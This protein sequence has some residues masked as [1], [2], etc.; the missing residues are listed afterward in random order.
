M[1]ALLR[2]VLVISFLNLLVS[3]SLFAQKEVTLNIETKPEYQ[4]IIKRYKYNTKAT[5]SLSAIQTI[6][7]LVK[8]LH[9][10]GY[11]LANF[12]EIRMSNGEMNAIV[13][14]GNPFEWL[15][16]SPGNIDKSI[17]RKTAY[18][19]SRF[20]NDRFDYTQ[21]ANIENKVLSYAEENGYPFAAISYDSLRIENNQFSASLNLE[22]G[23]LIKF[24]T[25]EIVGEQVLKSSFATRYLGISQG[26]NY[27]QNIIDG[28]VQR[29][30]RL[31]YLRLVKSPALTFQNSEAKISLSL[32]KRPINT[33]D[34]IIGFL[35][36]T[37]RDN[38]LLITGQFDLELYNPFATGKKIGLH[39]RRLSEETQSLRMNYF[40]P[41][42]L[43]SPL[44]MDV[45]FEF[46]KQDTTFTRRDFKIDF[47]YDLS[48][49][50]RLSFF[51]NFRATDL[52]A[53]SQYENSTSLPDIVDFSLGRYGLSFQ[54]DYLD[55]LF[56]PRSGFKL[57]L[58]ASVGN[59][60]I[61]QN[62]DLPGELYLGVD[63]KTLQYQYDLRIDNYLSIN[64]KHI[65]YSAVRG[66]VLSNDRLFR[67]DAYRLG[68]LNTIRGFSENFF[69]ATTY[70]Y[71]TV[72]SRLFFDETSY[73]SLFSDFGY[74]KGDFDDEGFS[75]EE[76][77][78]GIGA[79]INFSTGNGIFNFV[80]ALGTSESTGGLNFNQSKIHFGYTTRF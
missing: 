32:E 42:V 2:I 8:Q 30:S 26:A 39:W 43:R 64:P 72:E 56:L 61:R 34:G 18:K 73:L 33:I 13:D 44:S 52:L 67:N 80:Y 53:T 29:L 14:P 21:L 35:P 40:H 6:Q 10:D 23:P 75:G 20:S 37:S 11:L 4:S 9:N 50:G 36:N 31:P 12:T 63:L 1:F 69:F 78:L 25:V 28:V 68:G 65:F 47:A 45:D 60:T 5:D 16:L 58:S 24:D 46:L 79:G 22:L 59:K 49:H 74:I 27:D 70:A 41:N 7:S 77:V 48:I 17:I 54:L 3:G 66:G 15:L 38:G 51:T 71:S 76:L 55:D 57:N 19:K 62:A